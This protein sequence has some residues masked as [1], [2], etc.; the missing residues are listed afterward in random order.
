MLLDLAKVEPEDL[1]VCVGDL[2]R[3]GPDS[4]S[5]IRWAMKSPNVRCV[6]GNH[7]ARLLTD[8][9][10]GQKPDPNSPDDVM[11]SAL[12]DSYNEAMDCIRGWPLFLE[13]EDLLIVHAGVDP[14]IPSMRGQRAHDMMTIRV[15]EGLKGPWYEGYTDPRTIVFGHWARSEPVIRP[16]AIGLDTGCVYGEKLSALIMPERRILSVPA[17]KDYAKKDLS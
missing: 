15:P 9:F 14:R 3:K 13:L 17:L 16:N 5:V 7:E 1:I 4:A 12:G 2:V 8:W 10:S 11:R 6:L